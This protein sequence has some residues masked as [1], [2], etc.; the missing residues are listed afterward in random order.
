MN[1]DKILC[2]ICGKEAEVVGCIC[3]REVKIVGI[4]CLASHI[5]RE[6]T[7]HYVVHLQLAIK[8]KKTPS[9]LDEILISAFRPKERRFIESANSDSKSSLSLEISDQAPLSDKC[10]QNFCF[11]LRDSALYLYSPYKK[12]INTIKLPTELLKSDIKYSPLCASSEY[13]IYVIRKQPHLES[14]LKVL[15]IYTNR[16]YT[17]P[18][19]LSLR[20][21]AAMIYYRGYIYIFGIESRDMVKYKVIRLDMNKNIE[22]T[23]GEIEY[24]EEVISC[25]GLGKNIY[26]FSGNTSIATL[27]NIEHRTFKRIRYPSN[28]FD[29]YPLNAFNIGDKICLVFNK[30]IGI[31]DGL[32]KNLS[33][34]S[35]T[36]STLG[37]SDLKYAAIYRNFLYY[38]SQDTSTISKLRIYSSP[39]SSI[40]EYS[41]ARPYNRYI[42]RSIPH[43]GLYQVD[44]KHFTA[45]KLTLSDI[46][47]RFGM[48][49][50][51]PTGELFIRVLYTDYC[52]IYNPKENSYIKT[53]NIPIPNC[54]VGIIWHKGYVYAIGSRDFITQHVFRYDLDNKTWDILLETQRKDRGFA[55][56]FGVGDMIYIIVYREGLEDKCSV[57]IYNI[58]HNRYESTDLVLPYKYPK[59]VVFNDHIYMFNEGYL[60]IYTKDL[61]IRDIEQ[62][63]VSVENI[64]YSNSAGIYKDKLFFFNRTSDVSYLEFMDLKTKKKGIEALDYI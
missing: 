33:S 60:E 59:A 63:V 52:I 61:V 14:R 6:S 3:Y 7:S 39:H 38:F 58:E 29:T 26:I 24:V 4:C 51:L 22:E 56:L 31:Y 54:M 28:K 34:I 5:T 32:L 50:D 48:I 17:L 36:I 46:E 1:K 42:Y 11:S 53:P 8:M 20:K 30:H 43:I 55:S 44:L 45:K 13:G 2:E 62:G 12:T 10:Y 41:T 15:N 19:K 35:N 49:C 37:R 27:I 9:K 16:L 25:V 23:I 40:Q 21:R 47:M 64:S 57:D 18:F